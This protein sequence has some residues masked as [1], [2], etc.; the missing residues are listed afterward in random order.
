MHFDPEKIHKKIKNKGNIEDKISYYQ[1]KKIGK[2][3]QG[4][5]EIRLKL[6]Q[7]LSKLAKIGKKL[8]LCVF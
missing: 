1:L 3:I 2:K 7:N 4:I 6:G 8:V 5:S